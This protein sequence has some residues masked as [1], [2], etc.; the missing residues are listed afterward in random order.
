MLNTDGEIS[1]TLPG[2]AAAILEITANVG[3]F[4]SDEVETVG[5]LLDEYYADSEES[6][7]YFL[8]YREHGRVLGYVCWGPR[9]LSEG[10]YDLYWICVS[11]EAQ[12]K[13]VGRALMKQL[14]IEALKRN[15]LWI[16]IETS[17]TEHYSA[18]RQLY[19]RSS[20][21][22]SMELADFYNAGDNLVVYTR[23]LR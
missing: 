4:N 1:P 17:S 18:A 5:E 3:V 15:G 21:Q 22:K 12:G 19:E 6:G 2:E 11:K 23:R 10:G 7:Y 13:G 14:E 16:I 8:S 20:Y 9:P